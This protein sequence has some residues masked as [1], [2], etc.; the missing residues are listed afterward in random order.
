MLSVR[1]G[2]L[3]RFSLAR[4]LWSAPVDAGRDRPRALELFEL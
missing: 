4:A 2:A 1:D 3:L